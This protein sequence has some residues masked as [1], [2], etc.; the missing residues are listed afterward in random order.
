VIGKELG[1]DDIEAMVATRKKMNSFN[2]I[3]P[4]L[5]LDE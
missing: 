4:R 1:E 5:R 3:A 2:A